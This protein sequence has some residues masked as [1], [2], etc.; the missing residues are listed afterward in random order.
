[1]S[2]KETLLKTGKTWDNEVFSP[3]DIKDPEVTVLK[4][5]IGVGE[6]LPMHKH[7]M[8]NIAY[9]KQGVLT[10]TTDQNEQITVTE[11]ECLPEIIGKYHFGKNSGDV[12]VEL[13]V[14][15]VGEKDTPLSVNK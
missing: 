3:M 9:I 12:P 10:V 13:I 4:I 15:Y 6:S 1:M 2:K 8:M 11:G 5:T 14:F 7:D